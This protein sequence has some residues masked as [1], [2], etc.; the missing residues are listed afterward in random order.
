LVSFSLKAIPFY[1]TPPATVN[2][3]LFDRSWKMWFW[4]GVKK[5]NFG[6]ICAL[7]HRRPIEQTRNYSIFTQGVILSLTSWQSP[8]KDVM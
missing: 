5:S 1:Q 4:L 3:I 7:G 2:K 6:S 8:A